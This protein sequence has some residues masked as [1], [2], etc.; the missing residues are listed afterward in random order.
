MLQV[1]GC[2][3]QVAGFNVA[4]CRCLNS[5]D[6]FKP[7]FLNHRNNIKCWNVCKSYLVFMLIPV[8]R[9]TCAHFN[10]K[11]KQFFEGHWA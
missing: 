6:R 8:S 10:I 7:F 5:V 2:W 11:R 9:G 1:A 3:L 4:G